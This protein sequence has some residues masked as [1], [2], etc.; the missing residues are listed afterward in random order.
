MAMASV[1]KRQVVGTLAVML[2]LAAV[3]GII[4]TRVPTGRSPARIITSGF[5]ASDEALAAYKSMQ[6]G[7]RLDYITFKIVGHKVVVDASRSRERT[8]D[9]NAFVHKLKS[10]GEPR[11]GVMD[12][13]VPALRG[14]RR[15]VFVSWN[16]PRA[17]TS[18]KTLYSSTRES[19]KDE[20]PGVAKSVQVRTP[21]MPTR[22]AKRPGAERRARHHGHMCP[23]RAVRTGARLT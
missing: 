21:C 14:Q 11:Y 2:G 16:P 18:A 1:N 10:S 6:L 4:V 12:Y 8:F 20:L 19:F 7:H 13:P 23:S 3:V 15:I 9:F 22:R 5:R 17:H